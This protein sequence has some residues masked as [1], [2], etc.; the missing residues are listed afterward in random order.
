MTR[1]FYSVLT[2]SV[3]LCL[4]LF[5]LCLKTEVFPSL[6]SIGEETT[7]GSILNTVDGWGP[8]RTPKFLPEGVV[9]APCRSQRERTGRTSRVE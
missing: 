4:R 3:H 7:L 6:F 9:R 1:E 5:C 2:I 8:R